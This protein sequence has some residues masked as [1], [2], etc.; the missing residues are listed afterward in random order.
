MSLINLDFGNDSPYGYTYIS[1]ATGAAVTS[2]F[3]TVTAKR[4]NTSVECRVAPNVVGIT[5]ITGTIV[6]TT[7][8]P[9]EFRPVSSQ[10]NRPCFVRD[11]DV[12]VAGNMNVNEL[13]VITFAVGYGGNFAGVTGTNGILEHTAVWMTL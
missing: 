12:N 8:L 9:A 11:S 1:G 4:E 7:A 13:G 10:V 3:A 2:N 6:L 5:G